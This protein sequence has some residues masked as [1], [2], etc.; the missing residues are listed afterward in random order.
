[1][2]EVG[3]DEA[4]VACWRSQVAAVWPSVWAVTRVSSPA[5]SAAWPMI[6]ARVVGWSRLPSA[7]VAGTL[8]GPGR[9]LIKSPRTR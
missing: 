4:G 6:A 1:M 7:L 8:P 9:P 3:G 5:R 2:A